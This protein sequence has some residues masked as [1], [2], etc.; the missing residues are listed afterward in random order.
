M[1]HVVLFHSILGL[2]PVEHE[3]AAH[4]QR[5]GHTVSLPDLF[6]GRTTNDYDEGFAQRKEVGNQAIM[7]AAQAAVDSAPA[8]AVL[9]G[10]SF[11]AA[12]VSE[13]WLSRP[14]MAGALLMAGVTDWMDPRR[15]GFPISAHI[16]RPDPFDDDTFFDDWVAGAGGV[17]LNLHRYDGVGHYF[18]DRSLPDFGALQAQ[19]CLDRAVAFLNT[20]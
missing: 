3:I 16:A 17:A 12:L 13:F 15:P 18:L 5:H 11:G 14:D 10:V 8:S 19:L 7:A 2:R 4:F 20:L 6:G 9:A 1:A